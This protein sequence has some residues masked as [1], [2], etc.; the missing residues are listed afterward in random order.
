MI[1]VLQYLLLKFVSRYYENWVV[2]SWG[3]SQIERLLLLHW[4]VLGD[5]KG[6]KKNKSF[7]KARRNI[8]NRNMV[9][10][11]QSPPETWPD[12]AL[13]V[14][15]SPCYT[16]FLYNPPRSYC[17]TNNRS[18]ML[19]SRWNPSSLSLSLSRNRG[20]HTREKR[21]SWLG[22]KRDVDESSKA[23]SFIPRLSLEISKKTYISNIKVF[24]FAIQNF[25]TL[26]F[27][28]WNSSE[29]NFALH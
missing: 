10:G 6:W 9:Q 25:E 5:N 7:A 21:I 2:K 20:P 28:R 18:P 24:N 27:S 4:A 14:L 15:F 1:F 11:R 12:T 26:F 29:A 19:I 16:A 17:T 23:R 22:T 13:V 8:R 3:Y